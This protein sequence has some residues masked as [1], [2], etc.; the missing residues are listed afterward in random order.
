MARDSFK[1][2][3]WKTQPHG[4]HLLYTREDILNAL[5]ADYCTEHPSEDDNHAR[6]NHGMNLLVDAE[7]VFTEGWIA[8]EK[9][10]MNTDSLNTLVRLQQ[11]MVSQRHCNSVILTYP[12]YFSDRS[13]LPIW[14]WV[15]LRKRD[16]EPTQD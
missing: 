6:V 7:L 14:K 5:Y 1:T 11:A 10:P 12:S 4:V 15:G 8:T 3:I 2:E 16:I 13:P 9:D